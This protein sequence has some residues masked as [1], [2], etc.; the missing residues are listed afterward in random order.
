M[1]L[2]QKTKG[3]TQYHF[4]GLTV[5]STF[6]K[7]SA[8]FTLI[9]LLVVIAIIGLLSTL[10]VVSLN[11]AR[12]KSRDAKRLSDIKQIQTG[13]E[14]YFA[15]QNTYPAVAT[16]KTLGITGALTLT[17]TSGFSDLT[18]GTVYMSKVPAN[19]TPAATAATTYSYTST[20]AAG[21]ACT[22][23]T[24]NGYKIVFAL[25]G[26]TSGYTANTVIN[27]THAGVSH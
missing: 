12:T 16:A 3:F 26:A 24:C 10:A 17:S 19:P 4:S 15:D 8:G 13:L 25:E 21:V 14:L 27:A 22:T 2:K 5:N 9:E 20:T 6:C 11:N 23:G 7:K 1:I 18:T